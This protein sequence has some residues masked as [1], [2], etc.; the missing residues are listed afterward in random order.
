V[1]AFTVGVTAARFEACKR[2]FAANYAAILARHELSS[3]CVVDADPRSCDVGTRLAVQGPA[4]RRVAEKYLAG[5]APIPASRA[6]CRLAYPPLHVLPVEPG[7]VDAEHLRA[8]NAAMIAVRNEFDVVVVDLPVGAGRPGPTLDQ[9]MVDHVDL[10]VLTVT[11][12]RPALAATLRYLELF[13]AAQEKRE[14]A[15]HV[16]VAC[17]LTGDEGS[18]VLDPDDVEELLEGAVVARVPQLWGRAL[19]NVGF[20]PT[21][22]F[23]FLEQTIDDLHAALAARRVS[24]VGAALRDLA[25][26]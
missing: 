25:R 5:P 23:A 14:I 20:G 17:V 24:R 21:L 7:Y 11:P 3:V 15:P 22:G 12:D 4:L 1:P 10:L 6:I 16:R 9:R 26:A 19:P 8:Y 13:A 2:G 18:T